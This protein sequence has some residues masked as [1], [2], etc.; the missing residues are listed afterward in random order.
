[1]SETPVSPSTALDRAQ[2]VS[3]LAPLAHRAQNP[4]AE[5]LDSMEVA[6]LVHQVEQQY[7]VTL[8]IDDA[9]LAKLHTLTDATQILGESV[10]AARV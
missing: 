8:D 3:M 4:E 6:W 7:Q 9:A 10:A 5:R 2:L 1:M